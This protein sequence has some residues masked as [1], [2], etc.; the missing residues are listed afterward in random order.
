MCILST[1][2]KFIVLRYFASGSIQRHIA[3]V[4]LISKQHFGTILNDVC[5]AIC[6]A[7][8]NEVAELS[9]KSLLEISNEF[10][11]K[12]NF[13]NCLGAIDGKHVALKCPVNAGSLFYNY[14][15]TIVACYIEVIRKKYLLGIIFS[16]IS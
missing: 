12:W 6:T 10:N 14:K 2:N 16:D 4:Y 15:V 9:K 5:T 11:A 7:L 13:P 3:S 8:K 1:F